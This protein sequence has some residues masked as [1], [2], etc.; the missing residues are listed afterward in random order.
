MI[1][2]RRRR[3]IPCGQK[4][5]RGPIQRNEHS[6]DNHG[7]PSDT[8]GPTE[9]RPALTPVFRSWSNSIHRQCFCPDRCA[10]NR[11]NR[12]IASA[13]AEMFIRCSAHRPS[14]LLHGILLLVGT[15]SMSLPFSV[16]HLGASARYSNDASTQSTRESLSK[17]VSSEAARPSKLSSPSEPVARQRKQSQKQSTPVRQSV[18]RQIPIRNVANAIPDASGAMT[19]ITPNAVATPLPPFSFSQIG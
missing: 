6:A 3:G 15:S 11:C 1:E 18:L 5:Q 17:T 12:N 19:R 10:A 7:N 2:T 14:C 16:R 9:P 13:N 8:T 4:K